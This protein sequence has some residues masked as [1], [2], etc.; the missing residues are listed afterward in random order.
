MNR[1]CRC[2]NAQW[3]LWWSRDHEPKLQCEVCDTLYNV[4]ELIDAWLRSV[5]PDRP[6]W[7][8]RPVYDVSCEVMTDGENL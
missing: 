1:R 8:N 2:G 7:L 3:E 5:A 6:S 4:D